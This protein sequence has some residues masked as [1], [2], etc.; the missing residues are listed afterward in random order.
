MK[1]CL[2]RF[3]FPASLISIGDGGTATVSSRTPRYTGSGNTCICLC[4]SRLASTL[5]AF[6]SRSPVAYRG[7]AL[8]QVF[9]LDL[10]FLH[11]YLC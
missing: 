7:A 1:G 6:K 9:G 3:C 4:A 8:L 2:W 5:P 10:V 11:S